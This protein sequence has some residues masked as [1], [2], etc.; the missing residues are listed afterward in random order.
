MVTFNRNSFNS[1]F[2]AK[3]LTRLSF[4]QRTVICINILFGIIFIVTF[5]SSMQQ[6]QVK[7]LKG[8]QEELF[9]GVDTRFTSFTA[10]KETLEEI[11]SLH[12]GYIPTRHETWLPEVYVPFFSYRTCLKNA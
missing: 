1:D 11:V 10:H 4:F 5:K 3:N 12:G 7:D 9:V 8:D 6:I 2:G